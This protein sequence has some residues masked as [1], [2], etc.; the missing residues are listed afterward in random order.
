MK[1][2]LTLLLFSCMFLASCG[3]AA[4]TASCNKD[5]WDGTY[6]TCLPAG[7]VVMDKETLAARGV[8][9]ETVTAFK[10]EKSVSGQFP[11]ITVTREVLTQPLT[12]ADYSDASIRS[13]SVLPKYALIDTKK[14]SIDG[15]EVSLH[16]FSSQ[17]VESDPGRRF[18]QVSTVQDSVGYTVTAAV[19]MFIEDDLASQITLILE[20]STFVAPA[21][22]EGES[23]T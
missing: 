23:S 20:S 14:V 17:P 4:T 1:K 15:N 5:Y 18:F 10:A 21:E 19:P 12:P 6:G 9:S 11:T 2:S 3:T 13:V 7:W 16:T 22:E 8:P